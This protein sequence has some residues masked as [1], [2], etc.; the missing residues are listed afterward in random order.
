VSILALDSL[1]DATIRNNSI[2]CCAAHVLP[3]PKIK[4]CSRTSFHPT[5]IQQTLPMKMK[6]YYI[7]VGQKCNY[8]QLLRLTFLGILG[9]PKNKE[10][11]F[12][13][14]AQCAQGAKVSI[15]SM[16]KAR[17]YQLHLI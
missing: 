11:I 5:T 13:F 3:L 12:P 17:E 7:I 16:T 9:G 15:K 4:C 10:D 6:L 1:G 8:H 2:C 14:H